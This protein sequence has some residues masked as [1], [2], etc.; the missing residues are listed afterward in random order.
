LQ[1]DH[2]VL[3]VLVFRHYIDRYKRELFTQRGQAS[4]LKFELKQLSGGS[5]DTIAAEIGAV[6]EKKEWNSLFDPGAAAAADVPEHT[7]DAAPRKMTY[8]RLQQLI[9]EVRPSGNI[10]SCYQRLSMPPMRPRMHDM[11]HL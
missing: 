4:S 10:P 6:P 11:L 9:E 7:P 1:S 3:V 2:A 5:A 8:V